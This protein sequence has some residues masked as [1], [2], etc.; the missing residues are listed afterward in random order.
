VPGTRSR[1]PGSQDPNPSYPASCILYPA[2][3]SKIQDAG[4]DSDPSTL[5]CI[6]RVR[7]FR[8]MR[9]AFRLVPGTGY[10]VSG[11]GYLAPG[12]WY[13]APEPNRRRGPNTEPRGLSQTRTRI[14]LPVTQILK[15]LPT[16]NKAKDFIVVSIINGKNASKVDHLHHNVEMV[17]VNQ[18]KV[19]VVAH[20]IVEAVHRVVEAVLALKLLLA[21]IHPILPQ[22][23]AP[24]SLGQ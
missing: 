6:P 8:S 20:K 9:R 16:G 18:E 12:T 11:T 14:I 10:P 7:V 21:L 22:I 17:N 1:V 3:I 13:P 5:S 2:S 19:V 24:L 4:R 23:K 15:A